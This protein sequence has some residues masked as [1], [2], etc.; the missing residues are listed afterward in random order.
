[1]SS[2]FGTNLSQLQTS[3]VDT[4][5]AVGDMLTYARAIKEV[6]EVDLAGWDGD[7]KA[8]FLNGMGLNLPELQKLNNSLENMAL[9]LGLTLEGVTAH[10]ANAAKNVGAAAQGEGPR[11]L[12]GLNFTQ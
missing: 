4:K 9:N 12:P 2:A 6:V 8:S 10:E 5:A 11:A 7:A 3:S 1:M